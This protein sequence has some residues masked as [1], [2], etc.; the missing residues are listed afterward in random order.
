MTAV[1]DRRA[2]LRRAGGLG[3]AIVG[4]PL[5]TGRRAAAA[6]DR[7]VVAV[8]QWGI[9]TPLAWRSVQA[10]KPL[11]DSVYDPLITRDPKTFEYRP[12]LATEWKSSSDFKTWTFKL[13]SGVKFHEGY[14]ELTA[15][16]VKFTVEQ[17]LKPDAQGGSA[18]FFRNNLDRIETPD[19][20]TLVLHFK[21]R[22]WET[23]LNFTQFVG[24]QNTISKK[25]VESVGEEKAALH[26]IGTGPY[27]HVEGR[28]GD[29]HRFE[30]V[31]NHWR[32]TPAFKELVI[33]R[34]PE[35]A[36]RLSGL[37][38]GEIDIGQVFGDYL[39]QAKKV[40][41]KIHTAPN[42]ACNWVILSGQTTPDRED[43]CPACPWAGD[44][45]DK[46]SLENARKVRLAMNLAVNKKAII[47]GLWKGMGSETPFSYYYYPFHKGYSADWKIPPYDPER[48]K[49]LLAEAGHA[50]GFEVRVNPMVMAYAADGP[51]IMEA[52][53]LDWERVGI[54]SKRV[55]EMTSTFGPKSRMRKTNRTHWVYG[56]P[57]FDEPVLAWSRV[58][59]SKGAFNLL[60]DG[61]YD[62]DIETAMKELDADKRAK[63]S[64]AL[65]Q[66]LYDDYRGVMI[67]IKSITWAMTKKVNAWPTLAYVP[68][69]TNYEFIS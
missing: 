5:V 49:K 46:R 28:Q 52:V 34:V 60:C 66:K 65:G 36:T 37:R 63:L 44:P 14:G 68:M 40:G 8:S 26:P 21:N 69:E 19:K 62:E 53:S 56:S 38:A 41:L 33:R 20:S 31:P 35:P 18:P 55:P 61:P 15:E 50:S 39:E 45:A 1:V 27:R 7:L 25:Y 10:E 57:P 16:D 11:W 30:A 64:S 67:G 17:H 59:H 54:K 29:Y 12:G 58:L 42:S 23:P 13:R 47:Q 6:G 2:F 3:L 43:Y 48:A 51:D 24:Y 32:K 4:A 22:V 9:E